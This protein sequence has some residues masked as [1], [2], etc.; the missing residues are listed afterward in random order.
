MQEEKREILFR[1]MRDVLSV[2]QYQTVLLYYFSNLSISEVALQMGCNENAVKNRLSVSRAKLKEEI[3]RLE[4]KKGVKLYS[5]A[6][7]PILALIFSESAK[8]CSFAESEA[9]YGSI[10][11]ALAGANAMQ[12]GT[13][14]SSAANAAAGVAGKAGRAAEANLLKWIIG[15]LGALAAVIALIVVIPKLGGTKNPDQ[16]GEVASASTSKSQSGKQEDGDRKGEEGK[17]EGREALPKLEE[18][19]ITKVTFR[20]AFTSGLLTVEGSDSTFVTT[21]KENKEVVDEKGNRL[22][23]AGS[24]HVE[25]LGDGYYGITDGDNTFVT[26]VKDDREILTFPRV[27]RDSDCVLTYHDGVVV[28]DAEEDNVK[29][30]VAYD[31]ENKK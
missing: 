14:A 10:T 7:V 24:S 13:I 28:Y 5:F 31:L 3:L 15:G 30:L 4:E 21:D 22:A 18:R 1:I 29:Y 26:I 11:N 2:N 9:V 17:E 23:F 19:V 6:G 12:A 25:L 16:E 27:Q 8:C 20:K